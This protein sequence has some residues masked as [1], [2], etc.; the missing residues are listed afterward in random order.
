MKTKIGLVVLAL[1]LVVAFAS[2]DFNKDSL[3]GTKW[4]WNPVIG[5]T[6]DL[7]FTT[8]TSGT[9]KAT[10]MGSEIPGSS[11]TFTYTYTA[12]SKSG[13]IGNVDFTI[14]G[15]KMKIKSADMNIKSSDFGGLVT[16]GE[17]IEFTYQP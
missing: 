16:I 14:A 7:N 15:T 3:V 4:S 5:V 10:L 11:A 2:C 1:L 8:P 13:K 9:I 17:Y 6:M 12:A